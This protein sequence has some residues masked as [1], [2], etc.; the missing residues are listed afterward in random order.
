M[1]CRYVIT[2]ERSLPLAIRYVAC[3]SSALLTVSDIG[4]A[5]DYAERA[6]YAF[7]RCLIPAFNVLSGACRVDFDRVENR[8]MY[9]ALHRIISC[10]SRDG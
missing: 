5:S 9:T 3:V 6:L 7:D 4:A 8:P 1:A 2:N 10:V